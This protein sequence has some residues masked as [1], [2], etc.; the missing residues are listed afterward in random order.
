LQITVDEQPILE[1]HNRKDE[2]LLVY[3]VM[4]SQRAHRREN[5][6]ELLLLNMP[7]Q[8]ASLQAQLADVAVDAWWGNGR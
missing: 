8:A 1:S 2:A 3:L 7:D 6:V 5:L 4:E